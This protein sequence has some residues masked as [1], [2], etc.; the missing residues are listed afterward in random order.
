VIHNVG[1]R[2]LLVVGELPS[3]SQH[4]LVWRL[5]VAGNQI[6]SRRFN[7]NLSGTKKQIA[8]SHGMIVRADG[9]G[10]FCGFDDLFWLP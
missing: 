10:R 8:D 2:Q 5:D 3:R 1:E 9:G 6:S 4:A 7:R